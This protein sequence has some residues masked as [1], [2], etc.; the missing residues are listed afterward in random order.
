MHVQPFVSPFVNAVVQPFAN[1]VVTPPPINQ[2]PRELSLPRYVNYLAD[3]SGCGFWRI[4]WP[5]LFINSEGLGCSQSQTAMIF[6]PRWYTGV[7]CVKVQRQASND[8]KEFIKY[9][10]TVQREHGF[11]L[12]YEVDDVVFRE[13]IPDYNKFKFAFDNDEIRNNCI[14]IINMCDEV[15]VTC[16]YMRKLYQERTGKKEITVVPNFVPYHWMGHHFNKQKI[17]HNYDKN[18]RKPRVLYTGSGAHY[19]VDNK[20]GGIDDFSHVLDVVL[21]TIDKYQWVFVGAFPPP[22]LPYVKSGK[23]E[24]HPWQSLNKYP[25]FIANLNSQI[26]IAPLQDNTFNNS[27]SDIKFIE[28]CVLGLPC[29]VQDMETYKDAPAELK[30][31]TAADLE[32]KLEAVLKNKAVYYRN[33]DIFRQIGSQRFLELDQNIGCHLEVL[34]TPYGSPER[35]YL[36]RYNP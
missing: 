16:D 6:D 17:W 29:L 27:K 9:L 3:Y 31:K 11:K 20:N 10:K 24:F 26:M 23:I 15:V 7:K 18:K 25:E 1:N 4:L 14:E 8:Q 32:Q 36:K 19:D 33:V 35:K 28:A 5:E 34:N 12:V 30:F 2:Q 22:L 13:D 21:N